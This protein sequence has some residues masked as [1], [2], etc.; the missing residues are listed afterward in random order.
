MA[1]S[2]SGILY[3][4]FESLGLDITSVIFNRFKRAATS[5]LI[6]LYI[7]E[8]YERLIRLLYTFVMIEIKIVFFHFQQN[9]L[10]TFGEF[11][12]FRF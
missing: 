8:S 1:F 5:F 7:E 10:E 9:F 12:C 2:C 4:C 11:D 6:F 3:L